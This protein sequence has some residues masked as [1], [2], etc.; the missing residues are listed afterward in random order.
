[1]SSSQEFQNY[2]ESLPI[3][4]KTEILKLRALIKELYPNIEETMKYNLPDFKLDGLSLFQVASQKNYISFY[5]SKALLHL[6]KEELKHLNLGRGC[7]RFKKLE[8]INLEILTTI[9]KGAK[10]YPFE[11]SKRGDRSR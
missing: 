10:E 6:H 1:M 2:L 7:I 9:I 5:I 4:R 11:L 3:E 8:R